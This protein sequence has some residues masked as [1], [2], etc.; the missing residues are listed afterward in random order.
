MKAALQQRQRN[1]VMEVENTLHMKVGDG[2]SSYASNSFLQEIVIRKTLHVLKHTIKGMVNL[3]TAFSKVF[4]LADLGCGTGTN[5]LLLASMVIDLVLEL[6]KEINLK[7]PQFQVFLNDLFGNDFNTIF[8]LLPKF[9]ANLKKEKGE[10]FGS[11]FVSAIPG[12]FYRRL[13]PDESLHLVHSSY[14]V[15]WLSQVPEGI[16]NNKT[17]IYMARTSPPNVFEAYGKQFHTDFIKF[18]EL[19]AKEVVRGGCMVLTFLGR[20]SADPTTDDGCRLMELLA[21]S[22]LD[23]VK[24]G[25]VEESFINSFNLPHYSPCEDEVRKAIHNEGSFCLNTF[26]VFQGNWDPYDTDY[27][28]LVD[29]NDQI[30]H[31]HAK[32]CAKALRAVME[33]LLTSHFGNLIN[34]DVLFQ[35][36]QMHVAEDLANKK[37]RYFNIAISLSKK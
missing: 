21:Q 20:S 30:S 9:R 37:T 17:N 29:L 12:S 25:L 13:F 34:I 1:I 19:R 6:C 26:N 7:T 14:S 2:E 22:L 31:I 23:M 24:E 5:T 4:V 10:N 8:Q 28:N 27:T 18:L 33:P 3:E 35:K 16:E 32:N 11:C 36:L 15:H